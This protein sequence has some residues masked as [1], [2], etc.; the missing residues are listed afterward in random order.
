MAE[1][2]SGDS[3]YIMPVRTSARGPYG[4]KK[5]KPKHGK[6]TLR[7]LWQYFGNEKGMLLLIFGLVAVDSLLMLA[8]P[9]LIGRTIDLMA[10]GQGGIDFS[11]LHILLI[12]LLTVYVLDGILTLGENFLMARVSQ[13]IVKRL[14]AAM[15]ARLQKLSVRFFD[16]NSHGDLMSRFTNDIDNISTTLSQST[17]TLMSDGIGIIGSFA[18]MMILNPLLAIASLVTVP[19]VAVLTR[20][21]A[22]KTQ[23]LFKEQQNA[24]G[25]LNGKIEESIS[26]LQAVKAFN[27]EEKMIKD[28]EGINKE[29]WQVGLKAQI[30]SGYLMPMMNIIS[31]IGFATVA[32]VGG[33]MAVR[34]MITVGTVASFL[35]YSKQF[36]RP[37][38]EVAN[39]FNTLQTAVAGAE[40]IFELLDHPGEKEDI[41]EAQVLKY[42][43]GKLEFKEVSFSYRPGVPVLKKVS[44]Q[45]GGGQTIA[46]VGATGSG[47]TTLANLVTRFYDVDSGEIL[48]DG[49]DIRSYTMDSLRRTFG[50]VL[51]DTYLFTG[52]IRENIRY[53][54]LE[55][56]DDKVIEAA[57]FANADAFIRKLE[58]GYD[59]VLTENGE[60]LSEGQRQLLAIARAVLADP[61]I[62]I[63]D[64]ATSNVDTRTEMKIQAAMAKLMHDRTCLIIAHRL[65]TIRDADMIMV[66]DQGKIIEKGTHGELM[67]SKGYYFKLYHNQTKNDQEL[68]L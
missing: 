15:F 55:A 2:K 37:L 21:I 9:Y 64:E 60:N 8:I 4:R 22:G 40:R 26:G 67:E 32:G 47:K 3:L 36:S 19:L 13:S 66:M 63:L 1:K 59:T 12:V 53:G 31:N 39:I 56:S 43:R 57:R 28:F 54:R 52:T 30:W 16:Q 23:V 17:V 29:L 14:R 25:R 48:I 27:Q 44:F 5:E 62:L 38:N 34:D 33:M 45:A 68:T 24:L 50:M 65:S 58:R 10:G 11:F 51:Q 41:K 61:P 46:L 42:S 49:K 6:D 35:S 20:T 7:R 18:M